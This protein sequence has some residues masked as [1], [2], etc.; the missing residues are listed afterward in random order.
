MKLTALG[1]LTM[2]AVFALIAI[3]FVIWLDARRDDSNGPEPKN[4]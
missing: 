2:I 4:L 1:A 3:A